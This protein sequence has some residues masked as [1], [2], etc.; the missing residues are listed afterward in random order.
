MD[1]VSGNFILERMRSLP[2]SVQVSVIAPVPYFPAWIRLNE[3]WRKLAHVPRAETFSGFHA[4]HPRY[5]VFPKVG[6][7]TH[8]VSMFAGSFRQVC[9]NLKKTEYDL[10]DAHYVYP[11]GFAAALIAAILKKPLVVSARGSDINLFSEFRLIR[12]FIR[13]VLQRANG[14]IAVSD[15]LKQQM[16]RLGCRNDNLA[17]IANGVD[18]QKFMPRPQLAMRGRLGLPHHRPIAIAVGRLNENKGLHILIEAVARLSSDVMLVIVGEGPQRSQLENQIRRCGLGEKVKLVGTVP[19]DE[20]SSWY[21][22][23]DVFC[24]ASS[25]EGCPNVVLEAMACGRPVVATRVGG[26]PE[27]VVSSALG[28]LV[29]RNAGAFA[30]ALTEAFGRR[31]DHDAIATHAESHDWD[32]VSVQLMNV[33][34]QA[35]RHFH[36]TA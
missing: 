23:A 2:E 29:D 30:S 20:L 18:R 12:P 4:E 13:Q 16:V 1:P 21:S 19:H 9:R 11:D 31:W 5:F 10:I 27:L 33:Y 26:I 6:M 36:A 15:A 24:L 17:V 28:M 8:G 35:I 22:A 32:S 25:R 34:R 14:L 7:A 3:R